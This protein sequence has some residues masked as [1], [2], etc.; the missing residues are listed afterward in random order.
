M[1]YYS[2][3]FCKFAQEENFKKTSFPKHLHIPYK[4][5]IHVAQPRNNH[6]RPVLLSPHH[7]L[8]LI[9]AFCLVS[10]KMGKIGYL[11]FSKAADMI[12]SG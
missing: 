3:S 6:L 9:V 12:M 7:N 5:R 8:F 4:L 11:S 1:I 2:V 10:L